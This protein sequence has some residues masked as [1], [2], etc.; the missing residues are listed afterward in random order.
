MDELH[1][2]LNSYR[3]NKR[4][5]SSIK[6]A[7]NT[8]ER[9]SFGCS[10]IPDIFFDEILVHMK[11]S[12]I[13]ILVFMYIYRKVWIKPNLYK[14]HGISP[15]LSYTEM[16][17]HMTVELENIYSALKNLENLGLLETIRAG[18]YFVRRYFT[19]KLDFAAG[20]TYDDFDI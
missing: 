4:E 9:E 7:D 3:S 19:K 1:S 8:Y 10:A 20:Q 6:S 18:Q 13:E 5:E 16:A 17:S 15:I 2:I 14:A 11:L 12:R